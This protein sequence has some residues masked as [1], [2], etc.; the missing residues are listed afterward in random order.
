MQHKNESII[1]STSESLTLMF[2]NPVSLQGR[3]YLIPLTR[4]V[5]IVYIAYYLCNG[6][7]KATCQKR[8]LF[9]V[10]PEDRAVSV[11][12]PDSVHEKIAK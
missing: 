10:K 3:K 4:T 7:C 6:S 9:S 12:H 1:Y 5:N 11:Y 8:K 2:L